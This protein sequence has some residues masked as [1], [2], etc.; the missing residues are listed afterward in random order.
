MRL[1]IITHTFPP[2]RHSNAKRPYYIAKG[3]LEAG[4]E[5]EVWT[6]QLGMEFG[7][8]ELSHHPRLRVRRI[9]DPVFRW[10]QRIKGSQRLNRWFAL[11]T[12]GI[13]WPDWCGPWSK[14]VCRDFRCRADDFDRILAFVFPASLLLAG[15]KPGLVDDRWTFDFQESVTP[16]FR[17]SPRR[18]PIQKLGTKRLERLERKT[19]HQAGRVVFTAESNRQAYVDA[20]L[21][22][23]EITRH[24]PYFYDASIF[25]GDR[26]QVDGFEIRY[27]GGFDLHGDRN[28]ITFLKSLAGFLDKHPEAR[29]EARFV[30]YGN[31]LPAHDD[32]IDRLGLKDV[33]TIH[34]PL[35]YED[36]LE[37]VKR[38]P[39]LLLVVA[40]AHNLFMPSKIVDY[41]G[42]HRPILAFVPRESEMRRVL[43][44]AG[45]ADFACEER[46]IAGGAK[47]LERL[48]AAYRDGRLH[49][50]TGTTGA[51]S[52][53]VQIPKYLEILQGNSSTHD[54]ATSGI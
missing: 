2:S 37:G 4:W 51:W 46:D 20:D 52:S 10:H 6:S 26:P 50:A 7:E 48:W 5:V 3:A 25:T 29:S 54:H 44:Q 33:V 21:V 35:S 43:D 12:A 27:Y 40:E 47:A 1:L 49:A 15:E 18:S 32:H 28:P 9:D 16:Q 39:V 11:A 17:R 22:P 23:E 38:S 53:N 14:M 45:M 24:V 8:G 41:F 19:L 42:A 31:W 30:F 13:L 36:Y 34:G